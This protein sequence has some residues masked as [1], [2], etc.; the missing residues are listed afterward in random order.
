VLGA[1]GLPWAVRKFLMQFVAQREF[2]EDDDGFLFRSKMLTGSW[3]ELRVATPTTFSVLGYKV[4]TLITWEEDGRLL[5][6]KMDTTAAEG[7]FTSGWSTM[8]RI[9]HE[10]A[11]NELLI[12]TQAPEGQYRMWMQLEKPVD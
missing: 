4:D 3:N 6:S 5:V 1:Q 11:G 2:L 7:Y 12:T 8:T 9:T 10:R